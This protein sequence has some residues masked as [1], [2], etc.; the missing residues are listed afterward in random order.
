MNTTV[1]DKTILLSKKGMKELKREI[2]QLER[3][4]L[5]TL[6]SLRELEKTSDREERLERI[7][8]LSVLENIE[9]ELADKKLILASAKLAPR[10]PTPLQVAIGSVVD[11]IDKQGRLLRFTIVDSLEAN[12]SDGR[13]S[14]LCPLGQNLIGKTV[15]D[16]IE[17]TAG[18]V[19]RQLQLV[20]IS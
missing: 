16:I 12:P 11:L 20:H 6:Q 13:I 19:T 17:W 14:F 2:S 8:K 10:K 18:N 4:H 15:H 1:A 7:E 5:K 9:S 3:D